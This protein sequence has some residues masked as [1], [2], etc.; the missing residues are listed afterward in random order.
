MNG[1]GFE[2]LARTPIP[3]LPLSYPTPLAPPI[4]ERETTISIRN[5]EAWTN[6]VDPDQVSQNDQNL[7]CLPPRPAAV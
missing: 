7:H 1:V 2:I 4:P 3:K 5:R 6:S